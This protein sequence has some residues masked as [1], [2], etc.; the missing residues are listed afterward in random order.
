[1]CVYVYV[2]E[3]VRCLYKVWYVCEVKSSG[4]VHSIS[5]PEQIRLAQHCVINVSRCTNFDET[6]A[7]HSILLG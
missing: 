7:V 2:Y 3:R 6:R 4:R 5:V 1:M